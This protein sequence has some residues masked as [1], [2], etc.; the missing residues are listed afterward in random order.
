MIAG[1][2]I[3]N[4]LNFILKNNML[5]YRKKIS[6]VDENIAIIALNNWFLTYIILLILS[7]AGIIENEKADQ[8]AKAASRKEDST[9]PTSVPYTY[10]TEIFKKELTEHTFKNIREMYFSK[11]KIYFENYYV[12]SLKP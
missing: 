6:I 2:Q 5:K 8:L 7:H 9:E 1:S 11:G 10:S 12:E 4:L 3:V